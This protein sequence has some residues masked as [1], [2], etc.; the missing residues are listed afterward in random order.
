MFDEVSGCY[1][2]M[3]FNRFGGRL[4]RTDEIEFSLYKCYLSQELLNFKLLLCFYER[5]FFSEGEEQKDAGLER[6]TDNGRSMSSV[7]TGEKWSSNIL[8]YKTSLNRF[9]CPSF[10][11]VSII[12]PIG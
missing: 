1:L 2:G 7:E 3:C 5:H 6:E 9:F 10:D 11:F 12:Y 8:E 4:G